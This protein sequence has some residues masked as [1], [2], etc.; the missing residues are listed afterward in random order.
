LLETA[1]LGILVGSG[2]AMIV[3]LVVGGIPLRARRSPT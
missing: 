2:I 1:K 3:G